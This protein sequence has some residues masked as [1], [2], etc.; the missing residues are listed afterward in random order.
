MFLGPCAWVWLTDAWLLQNLWSTVP[1]RQSVYWSRLCSLSFYLRGSPPISPSPFE[2]GGHG[3]GGSLHSDLCFW[4]SNLG[5]YVPAPPSAR[6]GGRP[7]GLCFVQEV[8]FPEAA[9]DP[10]RASSGPRRWLANTFP[11]PHLSWAE[12]V[13]AFPLAGIQVFPVCPVPF[14]GWTA[15]GPRGPSGV[16]WQP[17]VATPWRWA[18]VKCLAS[19]LAV[20]RACPFSWCEFVHIFF[21]SS[22][23]RIR[24]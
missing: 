20:P 23:E 3:F 12:A 11:S 4:S 7:P 13:F 18:A 24:K 17:R 8:L 1:A 19:T 9:S 15:L 21:M 2:G 6:S 16:F 10:W 14:A 22:I 5:R